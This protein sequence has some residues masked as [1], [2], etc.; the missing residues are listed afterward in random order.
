MK[1]WNELIGLTFSEKMISERCSVFRTC[2]YFSKKFYKTW[3]I[4]AN[5]TNISSIVIRSNSTI[6]ISIPSKSFTFFITIAWE[7]ILWWK[8]FLNQNSWF[9]AIKAWV[10]GVKSLLFLMQ[11]LLN[12]Y[13]IEN[14]KNINSFYT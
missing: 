6:F 13:N 14:F 1:H 5:K 3:I 2:C 7:R 10:S 8:C 11:V 4:D 9:H 12:E